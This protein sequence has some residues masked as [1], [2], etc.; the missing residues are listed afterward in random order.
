MRGSMHLFPEQID[1]QLLGLRVGVEIHQQLHTA[2]KLFCRCP[3]GRYSR[4]HKAEV[5]RHMRP[6]LSEM[7]TYDGTALME[8][9]T[10]K[11]VVYLLDPASVCTY[12]IDDTPPFLVNQE[13]LDIALQIALALGCKIIDEVHVARKQYLD[14]SIPTGF[15]RT[16][17]VGIDGAVPYKGRTIRILQLNLEEDA[18][19]EVSDIGHTITFRTDRLG[20]PLAEIITGA[21]MQTPTEAA[22]VI[23]LI[24]RVV[25]ATGRVR[26][27]LGAV[28]QDVNVSIA[29]GT[30]CEIKGVPRIGLIPAL[31]HYE[32]IRQRQLLELRDA[33]R[34]RGLFPGS[35]R[36]E[37]HRL[38]DLFAESAFS[39]FREVVQQGETLRGIKL[40]GLRGLL[41]HPLG[42]GRTFADE[43]AGRVR[44]IACLDH[45]PILVHTDSF[46]RYPGWERELAAVRERFRMSVQ[47][48][49]CICH[50]SDADTNTAVDE[51]RARVAEATE[52]VPNE[53]RQAL[54]GG[55][56]DFER[57]LPGPDRM[58]PDT[59]HPPTKITA[60]RLARLQ[61]LVPEQP[62]LRSARYQQ[63][64]LSA[65]LAEQII[66][67]PHAELFE[68]AVQKSS[69]PPRTIAAVLVCLVPA[70]A[71]RG[72]PVAPI[73]N[74]HFVE[75]V[76]HAGAAS[77][78]AQQLGA[79][80]EQLAAFPGTSVQ[81]VLA[82]VEPRRDRRLLRTVV[83]QV[84]REHQVL[85]A[86]PAVA[87]AK[88]L[89]YLMGQVR[90][91]SGNAFDGRAAHALLRRT[92][93]GS[94]K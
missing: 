53:T 2:R 4:V 47:D 35:L 12:E 33:L 49:V 93:S 50:G 84:V 7:G 94:L 74:N 18:C 67:G 14:G 78:N 66:D 91:R 34:H 5:L 17:V 69:L 26:R 8:F 11:N 25:R 62:W 55:A 31:V 28:R 3:A 13:A 37:I 72:V 40:V 65:T 22:D 52:G 51:I 85:L 88:K 63:W 92:L 73:L 38:N 77:L 64:G 90:S 42:T 70:L 80:L 27:G 58:Y 71:R 39:P 41:N 83:A 86:D 59:D 16:M 76:R 19:R 89:R 75:L 32:A 43:L 82:M 30:R 45:A 9:K 10:K 60:E 24:S 36:Y 54:P 57:I 44:V 79:A 87:E 29:G 56:T 23:R 48:V 46:P 20:M 68:K 61:A 1:Y 21:D 81:E 6:T 15:Q